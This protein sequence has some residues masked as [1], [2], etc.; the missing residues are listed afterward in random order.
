MKKITWIGLLFFL[1]VGCEP[2]NTQIPYRKVSF[3]VPIFSTQLNYVGG[4]EYFTGGVSGIVV[5]RYDVNGFLAYDRACPHDW[6]EG[7]RVEV[8]NSIFL[9]D[10]LCGSMFNILDGSPI[11]GP[12]EDFL[13]SYYTYSEDE[14]NLR[15]YN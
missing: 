6:E 4:Y 5:Y 10:S 1:M 8:I 7:G 13:R 3:T 14:F 15:V 2:K 9:Y 12:A 11:S